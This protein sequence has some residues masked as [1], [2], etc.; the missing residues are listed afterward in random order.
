MSINI[1]IFNKIIASEAAFDELLKPYRERAD[2][3]MVG[4]NIF[5]FLVCLALAPLHNTLIAV[6]VVGLP[7]LLLSI[8]LMDKHP[9]ELN[10][11]LFM[12]LGFMI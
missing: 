7:T 3:I 2:R 5:L 4:M 8:W 6:G 12:A 11:R 10:T 1:P 9:G